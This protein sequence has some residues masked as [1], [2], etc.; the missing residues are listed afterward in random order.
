PNK[1]LNA[2]ALFIN[3]KKSEEDFSPTT[4]YDDYAINET[5]FHW[6]SQNN[7]APESDRGKSYIYQTK[8]GKTILLFVR[9]SKENEHGFTR[10][11]VFLGKATFVSSEG[12]KPMSI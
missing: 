5:L 7:V 2:E 6:Q 11:S 4:M 12:S 3:L 1:I 9:E 10:G 8:L